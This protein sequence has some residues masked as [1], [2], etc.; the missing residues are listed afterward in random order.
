V[1]GTGTAAGHAGLVAALLDKAQALGADLA[2]IVA[3]DELRGLTVEPEPV[4]WPEGARSLLVVAVA[5][6]P[7]RPELDWW[8]GR[9][10]PPG[11]RVLAR[12]VQ[13][14]CDLAGGSLGLRATHLPYHV[15]RGGIYLKDAA[16]LAGLGCVGLNNLLVTP[17]FG[18]RVRMRALALDEALP[19]TG[20][21]SFDP[22]AGCDAPCRRACPQAVFAVPAE[23]PL[24]GSARPVTARL[25]ARTGQ[26]SRPA[27]Y[28]QMDL[29]IESAD[30]GDPATLGGP[31]IKAGAQ[32]VRII[33]YCRA[34]ELSCPVGRTPRPQTA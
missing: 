14:L 17:E 8:F 26:F 21:S 12:I 15:E 3:V 34:C 27:C 16:V 5:H 22:C 33:R 2:G 13:G 6:L 29:D 7:E 20:P 23:G 19:S 11:N 32:P 25:P 30:W 18:P 9:I 31:E 1:I 4:R 24:V 10:D 28:A